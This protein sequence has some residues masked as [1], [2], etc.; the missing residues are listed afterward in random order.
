M[1]IIKISI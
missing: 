1:K